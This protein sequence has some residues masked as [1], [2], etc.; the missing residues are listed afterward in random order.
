MRPIRSGKQ[1]KAGLD[2]IRLFRAWT[3]G[4]WVA[5]FPLFFLFEIFQIPGWLIITIVL[6]WFCSWFLTALISFF[7]R[8]PACHNF[9]FM[10]RTLLFG[11][12]FARKCVNCGISL[13]YRNDTGKNQ[14]T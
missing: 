12:V 6:L 2:R 13:N 8:C 10:K 4:I 9:F 14:M 3:F 5:F 1:I 7:S 11:N